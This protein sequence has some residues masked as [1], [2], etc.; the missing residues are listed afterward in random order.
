M[1]KV[2]L[3]IFGAMF[4][5]PEILWGNLLKIFKINFLP[6]YK[7]V[8]Y[9]TDNPK[10]AFLVIIAEIIGIFGIIYFLNKKSLGI[11]K[12]IKYVLNALLVFISLILI[13]SLYL[14]SVM[15]QISF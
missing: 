12:K 1:Q 8:Q 15:S 10:M 3:W 9:F 11:D 2:W 13:V 6:I 14:S 7:D 4:A 5:V